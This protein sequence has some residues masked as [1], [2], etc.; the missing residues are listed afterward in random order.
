[1]REGIDRSKHIYRS[2]R[3]FV[4]ACLLLVISIIGVIGGNKKYS[5]MLARSS[6]PVG[7]S[8]HFE[9][10]KAQMTIKNLFTD[11]NED[12]LIVRFGADDHSGA[13]LPYKG[14]DFSVMIRNEKLSAQYPHKFIEVLF[15]K[16]ASDGD[17]FLVIPKPDPDTVYEVVIVN[18]KYLPTNINL[19]K[20]TPGVD[21]QALANNLSQAL[22]NQKYQLSNTQSQ[23]PTI[24]TDDYDLAA[25]RLALNP[26]LDGDQYQPIKLDANLL[27]EDGVFDFK[28]FFDKVFKE[29]SI[30]SLQVEYSD[31]SDGIELLEKSRD[32]LTERII[33]NPKDNQALTKKTEVENNIQS[34]INRRDAIIKELSA[35]ELIAY[36]ETEHFNHLL[37]YAYILPLRK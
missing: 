28:L 18:K 29:N 17:F 10:S 32:A 25:F 19:S 37:N 16:L 15:G 36:D 34:L 33:N 31:L 22:A 35:L 3:Y 24:L 5:S 21:E 7:T 30:E 9:R 4:M 2:N 12:V 23:A 1:M 8:L 11:E 20:T 27:S 26:S 6:S 13:V 14:E